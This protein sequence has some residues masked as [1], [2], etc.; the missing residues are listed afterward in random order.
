MQLV[1][2]TASDSHS[3]SYPW[4]AGTDLSEQC[5]AAA[6][7]LGLVVMRLLMRTPGTLEEQAGDRCLRNTSMKGRHARRVSKEGK[8]DQRDGK[9][10]KSC[11]SKQKQNKQTN[12]QNSERREDMSILVK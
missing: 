12:K 3:R 6:G 9:S 2:G 8:N 7:A 4:V 5:Y 10:G 11:T 1:G